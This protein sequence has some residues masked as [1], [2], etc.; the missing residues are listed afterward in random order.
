MITQSLNCS[1]TLIGELSPPILKE[2]GLLPAL[3]WLVVWMEEKHGLTVNYSADAVT[4]PQAEGLTILL[5]QSVKEL[6]LN[7]V[8]HAQVKAA[9][10]EIRCQDDRLLIQITDHGVGFE[11]TQLEFGKEN[12]TGLGLPSIRERL[13]ILGGELRI[14]SAPGQGCRCCLVVP[15]Q[16][17]VSPPHAMTAPAAEQGAAAMSVAQGSGREAGGKARRLR[18]LAV[19]DHHVIR[20]ALVRLL[21]VA[22]DIEIVGEASNGEEAV[23]MARRLRPDVVTMDI[24]MKGMGGIEATRIIHAELPQVCVIGLSMFDEDVSAAAMLQAGAVDYLTKSS[25]AEVLIAAIRSAAERGSLGA[26]PAACRPTCETRALNRGPGLR[27]EMITAQAEAPA[28]G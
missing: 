13:E 25:P 1:R 23:Q 10:V 14:E 8:K 15:G 3:E 17:P 20:Q 9:T 6:L 2:R 12:S 26:E 19:D 11:A 24:Q 5:F 16:E 28:A 22:P 7:V 18:L 21:N 27:Q 4:N